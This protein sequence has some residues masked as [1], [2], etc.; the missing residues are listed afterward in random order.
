M[1][2]RS[3]LAST[4]ASTTGLITS[5]SDVL[6]RLRALTLGFPNIGPAVRMRLNVGSIRDDLRSDHH[7]LR[8][9]DT[10]NSE[11]IPLAFHEKA[12]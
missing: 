2:V 12:V 11:A 9:Q 3:I 10:G 1:S 7:W 5:E 8:Q 4:N 6:S